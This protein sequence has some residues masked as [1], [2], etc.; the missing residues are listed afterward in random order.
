MSRENPGEELSRQHLY[1]DA[2]DVQWFKEVFGNSMGLSKAVRVVMRSYRQKIEA[3]A[4]QSAKRVELPA[5][6]EA[7]ILQRAAEDHR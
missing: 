2:E 5:D 3:S 6:L 1:L 7:E 4:G